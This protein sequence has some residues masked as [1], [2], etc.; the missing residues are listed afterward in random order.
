M[1]LNAERIILSIRLVGHR[2]LQLSSRSQ[3]SECQW[4][5]SILDTLGNGAPLSSTLDGDSIGV[6]GDKL[7][8]LRAPAS[9]TDDDIER[10][11]VRPLG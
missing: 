10:Y 9:E 2:N 8:T 5:A 3:A 11:I 4:A 7:S 1:L 6:R